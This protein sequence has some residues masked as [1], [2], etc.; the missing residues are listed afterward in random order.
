[1]QEALNTVFMCISLLDFILV[2][3]LLPHGACAYMC[4]PEG[5]SIQ[6]GVI[7]AIYKMDIIVYVSGNR[8]EIFSAAIEAGKVILASVSLVEHFFRYSN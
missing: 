8:T 3:N 1:M 6:A 2:I 4:M 5:K 7:V